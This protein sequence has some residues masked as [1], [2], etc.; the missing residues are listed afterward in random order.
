MTSG[1]LFDEAIAIAKQQGFEIRYEHLG[2]SGT[3]YCQVG[4]QRWLVVDVAQ[5]VEEQLEQLATAI[6][7]EPT[8]EGLEMSCELR[9]LIDGAK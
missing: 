2:G 8:P 9:D 7:S 5:P 1:Q 4:E 6:A 3:G